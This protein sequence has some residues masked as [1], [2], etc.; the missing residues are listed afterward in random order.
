MTSSRRTLGTLLRHLLD[1]LDGDVERTYRSMGLD[2]RP[3]F[4][5]VMRFLEERG[6]APIREIALH[7]GVSHPGM[8]QTVSEMVRAGL[9]RLERGSDGR[10]RLVHLT[11]RSMELLPV[12]KR[13]WSAT[14]S[15]A[16]QLSREAGLDLEQSLEG[17]I[18]LLQDRPFADRIS[19]HLRSGEAAKPVEAPSARV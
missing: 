6:A 13:C 18:R 19:E 4:T 7:A 1:L 15:A 16:A 17:V 11:E 8:S 9:A 3:R 10:E 2:Y 12:L 14:N 5:P